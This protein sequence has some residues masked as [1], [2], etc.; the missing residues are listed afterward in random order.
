M[1]RTFT[2]GSVLIA[3]VIAG[4]A[5]CA[6]AEGSK[7]DGA[8]LES[9][10]VGPSVGWNSPL[11]APVDLAWDAKTRRLH[12]RSLVLTEVGDAVDLRIRR[13]PGTYPDGPISRNQSTAGEIP[14]G[15]H[16]DALTPDGWRQVAGIEGALG[17]QTGPDPTAASHPGWL[18]FYTY[19]KHHDDS[20]RRVVIDDTGA[21]SLGGGGYGSEGLP[22]PGYGLHIFGGGLRVQAVPSSDAPKLTVVG[23]GGS[24]EYTYQIVARDSKGHQTFPC[25]PS[26]IRGPEKL[27][28]DNF[29][30][31]KWD[32]CPGG[33]SYW[34]IRNG[35]RID[36]E[37][38]GEGN[39]KTF[40]D[41]GL[42]TVPYTPVTRNASADAEIDGAVTVKQAM[43]TPG[44][45][46]PAHASGI[47][48][49]Y[50]PQG[51]GEAATLTL[52]PTAP[53]RITGLQAPIAEG[54]WLLVL[55]TAQTTVTLANDSKQSKPANTLLTGTGSDIVLKKD[56]M[57]QLVYLL[58]HWRLLSNGQPR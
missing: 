7:W 26:T 2:R 40:D 14:G 20:L 29:I 39:S 13:A 50:N 9:L 45:C 34:I 49:D 3:V 55:N 27:S 16:W 12:A 54:R 19:S 23:I 24:T 46:A 1:I 10:I 56:Q 48:H 30:R 17:D 41:K 38:Y 11:Q 43:Y 37:F 47:L 15:I 57:V 33:E 52:S 32:R 6:M 58:G 36:V 31:L 22:N 28:G 53:V 35:R 44:V 42:P 25:K 18:I 4:L 5:S 8:M 21:M 51:L